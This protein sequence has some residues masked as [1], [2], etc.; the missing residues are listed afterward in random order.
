MH[1]RTLR[2]VY[3]WYRIVYI[4][5]AYIVAIIIIHVQ[6]TFGMRDRRGGIIFFEFFITFKTRYKILRPQQTYKAPAP[7]RHDE[8]KNTARRA[9]KRKLCTYKLSSSAA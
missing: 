7:P 1:A 5:H 8:K 3:S 2:Q 6:C 9:I 4:L